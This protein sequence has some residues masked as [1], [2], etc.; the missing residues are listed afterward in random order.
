MPEELHGIFHVDRGEH[1]LQLLK[2]I[3]HWPGGRDSNGCESSTNKEILLMH[4]REGYQILYKENM[5]KASSSLRTLR[6]RE[7]VCCPLQVL[8]IMV[9]CYKLVM[10]IAMYYEQL[11]TIQLL[12]IMFVFYVSKS[13]HSNASEVKFIK[14][15][16]KIMYIKSHK[17]Q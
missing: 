8:P 15:I 9:Y 10:E 6:K 17:L 4:K 14:H 1:N 5:L 11:V 2:H 3:H 12:K 16:T 13:N 7:E